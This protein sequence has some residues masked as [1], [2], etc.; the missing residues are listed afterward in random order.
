MKGFGG[1]LKEE[2][3]LENIG[4]IIITIYVKETMG[5]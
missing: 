2:N 3:V 1:S 4:R 5:A